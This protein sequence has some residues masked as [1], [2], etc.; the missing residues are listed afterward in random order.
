MRLDILD[1]AMK[2]KEDFIKKY[3]RERF[4]KKIAYEQTKYKNLKEKYNKIKK[5]LRRRFMKKIPYQ[6]TDYK[7]LK[8]NNYY[9]V[10][11]T[12]FIEKLEDID[13]NYLILLRPSDLGK[14]LFISMLYYYY[15]INHKDD[16]KK[17]YKDTYIGKNP[18]KEVNKYL[19]M[20][21]DFRGIDINHVEESFK[22]YLLDT[23]E[24]FIKKYHLKIEI[25]SNPIILFNKILN[26]LQKNRLELMILIDEYDSFVNKLLLRKEWGYFCFL[27][28][29]TDLFKQFFT[30]VKIATDMKNSP[31]KRMF[32]TGI[33]LLKMF[34]GTS[35]FQI[36]LNISMRSDLNDII[37]F[38]QEEIDT[39]FKYYKMNTLKSYDH[40]KSFNFSE[41]TEQKIFPQ[42]HFFYLLFLHHLYDSP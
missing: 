15:D 3:Y 11:K 40:D 31:L 19:M 1:D 12:K 10:D 7:N 4:M 16:F 13:E 23:L 24:T 39:M 30:A 20:K 38:T 6:E 33:E 9:L 27:K 14:S 36:G 25:V 41:D 34:D 28:D 22:S 26:Y 17:L 8:E 35:G 29:R 2:L 18:T 37:G 42:W 5:Y 21:F 32:I